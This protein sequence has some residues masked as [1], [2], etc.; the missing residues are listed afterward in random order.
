MAKKRITTAVHYF[1][2]WVEMGY[3]GEDGEWFV[4]S[5]KLTEKSKVEARIRELDDEKIEE[6]MVIKGETLG[7]RKAVAIID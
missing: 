4:E 2:C 5:Y 3:K 1:L 6:L 7:L